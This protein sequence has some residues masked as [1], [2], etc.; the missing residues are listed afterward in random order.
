MSLTPESASSTASNPAKKAASLLGTALLVT[1][2]LWTYFGLPLTS[3]ASLS[4]ALIMAAFLRIID[5]PT[6]FTAFITMYS[7]IVGVAAALMNNVIAL[8]FWPFGL[9]VLILLSLF[10]GHGKENGMVCRSVIGKGEADA[11]VLAYSRAL[12]IVWICFFLMIGAVAALTCFWGNMKSWVFWNGAMAWVL[13][14]LFWGMER[15]ARGF[16][17]KDLRKQAAAH[18]AKSDGSK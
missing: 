10:V 9:C 2:P 4:I 6:P 16:I 1:F 12:S 5:R 18:A 17:L 7:A 15:L 14:F 11:P 13:G 3:V 8:K